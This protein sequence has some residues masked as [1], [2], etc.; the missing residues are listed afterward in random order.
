MNYYDIKLDRFETILLEA[1]FIRMNCGFKVPRHWREEI[2]SGDEAKVQNLF[3]S[4]WPLNE[5]VSIYVEYLKKKSEAI[6]KTK[7]QPAQP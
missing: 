6:D 7:T 3:E 4:V 5:A 1:G 2:K